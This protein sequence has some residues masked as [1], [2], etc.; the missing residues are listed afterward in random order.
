MIISFSKYSSSFFISQF[1]TSSMNIYSLVKSILKNI[2]NN[3]K[4]GESFVMMR[5]HTIS[6]KLVYYL[7]YLYYT[8]LEI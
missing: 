7:Q 6:D 1:D 3:I 5:S 8:S 4:K 2:K